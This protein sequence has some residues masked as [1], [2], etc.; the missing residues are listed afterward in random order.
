MKMS[1]SL[2]NVVDPV[3]IIEGGSDQ[4]LQPAYGAD[5]LRL[6]VSGVDYTGDVCVGENIMKQV[7]DN[8]R[9]IRNTL[10]FLVGSLTDFNPAKDLVPHDQL[11]S[12]DKYMLGK[13]TEVVN[14]V[15]QAYDSYQFF[16]VVQSLIVF[17]NIEVSAFYLD[18]AKDRLY[19]SNKQDFRRK[20]CQTVIYYLLEQLTTMLAPI[21]PHMAEDLWQNI[22]YPKNGK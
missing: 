18:L 1:K 6:W 2:G 8:S 19:I 14:E 22:P 7:S 11:P 15:E 10:R 4:K 5:T 13:L 3:K 12:I 17:C 20:S 16:R 21:V 9:K